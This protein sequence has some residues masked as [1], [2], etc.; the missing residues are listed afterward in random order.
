MMYIIKNSLRSLYI[1]KN[2]NLF[3]KRANKKYFNL[4]CYCGRVGGSLGL[5]DPP[6]DICCKHLC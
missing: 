6:S 3:E 4:T 2:I 5:S 1:F